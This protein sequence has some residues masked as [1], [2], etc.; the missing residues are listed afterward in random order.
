MQN[1]NFDDIKKYLPKYLSDES[2]KVLFS[3]LKSFPNNIDNRI[4]TTYL[5]EE[6]VIFQGDGIKDMLVINLPYEIIKKVPSIIISNTCDSDP[7]NERQFESR[8]AYC[9]IF[10]LEKYKNML[11]KNQ[12]E[13]IVNEHI[14]TIKKQQITQI[15]YLPKV[16]DLEDSI[17]FLDR[18]NNC[19]NNSINRENIIN[20]RL[21]TLS[22]YGFYLFLFKLSIHFT[23]IKEGVERKFS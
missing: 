17:V 22:D 10:N 1:N 4:Y 15:F 8:I 14:D 5:R 21:F 2:L 20:D 19:S 12:K 16:G 9:P 23:R 6:K 18:I 13:S 11:V 7:E 3:E